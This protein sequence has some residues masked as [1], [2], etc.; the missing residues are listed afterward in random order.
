MPS[1]AQ[2]RPV[3]NNER[4]LTNVMP[5]LGPSEAAL[6]MGTGMVA[7]PISDM[8]GMFA[9]PMHAMGMDR[10]PAQVR[11]QVANALTYQ[12]R[13]E[14]GQQDA[15][16]NPLALIARLFSHAGD[17]T[18]EA[19]APPQ[20]SGP[21]R[22][23]AGNAL[24]ETVRQ[25]PAFLGAAAPSA[26][27]PAASGLKTSARNWM[28]SALKPQIAEARSG[29]AGRAVDTLLDE[30]VNV[31]QGG[32]ETLRGIVDDLN[33][34][35][36]DKIATSNA[37]VDKTAATAPLDSILNSFSRQ[38]NPNADIAAIRGSK[39]E[40]MNHPSLPRVTPART[41]ESPILDS[42]GRPFTQEIPASGTE[43]IP[44]QTAQ[45]LKQGTYRSLGNKNYG[46]LKGAEVEAQKG[47]ARGLKDEVANAEPSVG[48]L[49][50]RE[51]EMLNALPMVE[52]Q[53]LIDLRKNPGGIGWLA[54]NAKAFGAFMLGRS[55]LFKSLAARM[56]NT[57]SE[58]LP[59]V[60]DAAP[61]AGAIMQG[62]RFKGGDPN[63]PANWE[64][65]K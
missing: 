26:L 7:K 29:K 61:V 44:I 33:Q 56:I 36:A 27:A 32:A 15:Q 62:Y 12:P 57:T 23:A 17:V 54:H 16:N 10:D 38:V 60:A 46:E 65:M 18:K 2:Q 64:L 20:R 63:T 47:L 14:E 48:P 43:R 1:A 50:A 4:A 37:T 53:V 3:R 45:E 31:T 51:S 40:F 9:I 34:K 59:S 13:T 11:D 24:A 30:G 19:V 39:N 22:D 58:A 55:P 21:M 5:S 25:L 8:A 52:R 41:V 35:I 42:S 49:N 28:T 6:N